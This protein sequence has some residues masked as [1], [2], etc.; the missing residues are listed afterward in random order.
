MS[1]VER[2]FVTAEKEVKVEVASSGDEK[3]EQCSEEKNGPGERGVLRIL[4]KV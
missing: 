3:R 2:V 1:N 4:E